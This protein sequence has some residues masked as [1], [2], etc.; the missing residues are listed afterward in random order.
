M[1]EERISYRDRIAGEIIRAIEE[2]TAPWQKPWEPGE[3][4]TPF[5]PVTGKP[6]RGVNELW[7]TMQGH[8]DPRWMTYRQALEAGAQVSKGSKA[9]TIE[10]WQWRERK[11]LTD[12]SGKPLLD[13][14]GNRRYAE[15]LLDRPRVYYASVFNGSQIEGLEPWI[16]P[17]PSFDPIERAEAIAA[18]AGVPV[19]H[20][21]QD[22]AFYNALKDEIHLNS[23]SDFK[24]AETY[25]AT[26]LHE[27]GHAT[28]HERRLDRF[29]GPP[30]AEEYAREE[31]RAEIASY[32][33]GRE[34]GIG[35]DPG[36]H[37]AYAESWLKALKQDKHE[38]FRAARDAEI[39]KS[40]VMEPE[41]RQA[42]EQAAQARKEAEQTE[43]RAMTEEPAARVYLS[44]PFAE[45]GAAREAGARFDGEAKRW[46]IPEGADPAQLA[47]WAEKPKQAQAE[48]AP[49]ASPVLSV[50]DY[51]A[52][53]QAS[54]LENVPRGLLALERGAREF[55]KS[56]EDIRNTFDEEPSF[57]ELGTFLHKNSVTQ[58][59][60]KTLIER[61][62]ISSGWFLKVAERLN[63]DGTEDLISI[64]QTLAWESDLQ[65]GP[66]RLETV[67]WD[68]AESLRESRKEFADRSKTH[69]ELLS[70]VADFYGSAI[71]IPGYVRRSDRTNELIVT[72]SK[73]EKN[74]FHALDLPAEF[75]RP[76]QEHTEAAKISAG[77]T[78]PKRVFISV[79]Y[80]EKDHAHALGARWSKR[81][82]SWWITADMD[83]AP[84]RRWMRSAAESRTPDMSAPPHAEFGDFLK[85]HGLLLQGEPVMDGKWHYVPVE[86]DKSKRSGSY[87]GYLPVSENDRAAGLAKNFK[88]GASAHK[89]VATGAALTAEQRADLQ[90]QAANIRAQRE[91]DRRQTAEK[92]ARKAFGVW[93]NLPEGALPETCPYLAAKGVQGY[94]VKVA[95]NGSL[96]VPQRDAEGRFWGVQFC[97]TEG[98]R[99]LK[100]NLHV[101]TMHVIEPSGEGTLAAA[102]GPGPI[103]I[104]EGYATSSTIYDETRFPV[105]VAFDSGNLQLVAEAV[106]KAYPDRQIII[107][108]DNDHANTLGVNVGMIAGEKVAQAVGTLWLAPKFD[109]AEKSRGLTDFNDL[110][111]SRGPGA[112][113]EAFRT[114][115]DKN[116]TQE[117]SVA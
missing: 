75:T 80:A 111:Q 108:A 43:E 89:W 70:A 25:Y 63:L 38:I 45:R 61:A 91:T 109:E 3:L 115:L 55:T 68:Q 84:F 1:A 107:A 27:V 15:I 81:D 11:A 41:K 114:L 66:Q 78:R 34:L 6:Y 13:E 77:L 104:A 16:A 50:G 57:S 30:G 76:G 79:P 54:Q 102:A 9:E 52:L 35:F 44:V 56:S 86:G 33:L 100:G 31:L 14:D 39:I 28:G 36:N 60:A 2:G 26:L 17:A 58:R 101:G 20:D 8:A 82:K 46:Y 10:Y 92:A 98:K 74:I 97:T 113:R 23:R 116:R 42:L 67:T 112:V 40:W 96:V 90:A 37:A 5:N 103:I 105:V 18:G 19:F 99:Y 49:A 110:R 95:Q 69:A 85:A 29:F 21:Q 62:E 64:A 59:D 48:R 88:D 71:R 72:V 7:L 73:A 106:R 94:G 53:I 93:T 24:S 4:V 83:A 51:E 47:Q 87:I 22:R 65:E 32:M 12:E 117:L